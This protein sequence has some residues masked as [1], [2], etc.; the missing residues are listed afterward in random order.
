V[1]TRTLPF[2]FIANMA[3]ALATAFGTASSSATLPITI[4]SLENKNGVDPRVSKFVL[5]IGE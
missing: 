5:P 2:K 3:N 1:A 4:D